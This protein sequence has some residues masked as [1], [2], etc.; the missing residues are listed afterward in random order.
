MRRY[1]LTEDKLRNIIKESVRGML[2]ENNDRFEIFPDGHP[3]EA[4]LYRPNWCYA[5]GKLEDDLAAAGS[6]MA[7][8]FYLDPSASNMLGKNMRTGKYDCQ[9]NGKPCTLYFMNNG[10]PSGYCCYDDDI[11]AKARILD[12]LF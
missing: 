10:R 4:E 8:Y 12:M 7:D 6:T 3:R 9:F 5:D 1:R 11:E 2:Y